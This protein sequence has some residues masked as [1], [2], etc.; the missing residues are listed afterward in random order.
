RHAVDHACSH[1]EKPLFAC[2]LCAK[3]FINKAGIHQHLNKA[4]NSSSS[5][6]NYTD[7]SEKYFREIID[8]L[9]RCFGKI[10]KSL[11]EDCVHH[12]KFI[13]AFPFEMRVTIR[14]I[15]ANLEAN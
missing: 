1:L 12:G 4:H 11:K 3:N 2:R 9:K 7:S 8:M 6:E 14:E 5:P 10:Q 15:F 13:K